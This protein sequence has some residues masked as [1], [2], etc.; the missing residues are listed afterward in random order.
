[1]PAADGFVFSGSDL[2]GGRGTAGGAG[3]AGLTGGTGKGAGGGGAG[4]VEQAVSK[5]VMKAPKRAV[6]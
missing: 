5:A 6:R 4:G 2:W 1:V 3:G